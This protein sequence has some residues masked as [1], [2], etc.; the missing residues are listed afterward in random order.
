MLTFDLDGSTQ[1]LCSL[2]QSLIYIILYSSRCGC[3]SHSLLTILLYDIDMV[4]TRKSLALVFTVENVAIGMHCNL[5]PPDVVLVVLGFNYETHNVQPTN[6]THL[7]PPRSR[8]EPA[9]TKY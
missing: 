9:H 2:G 6:S 3:T 5:R 1:C 8:N 4:Q 7:Q